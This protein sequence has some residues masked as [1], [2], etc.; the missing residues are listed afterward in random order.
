M[1]SEVVFVN[2]VGFEDGLGFWGGSRVIT[3][4]GETAYLAE[5]FVNSTE[6]VKPGQ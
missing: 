4:E 2:R 6:I 3:P 1:Q 5:K